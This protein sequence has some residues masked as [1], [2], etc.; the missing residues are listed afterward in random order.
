MLLP[1]D[2]NDVRLDDCGMKLM[3][4]PMMALMT[5]RCGPGQVCNRETHT[6]CG[7]PVYGCVGRVQL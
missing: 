7:G 5:G 6:V 2:D 4:M 1:E 3:L